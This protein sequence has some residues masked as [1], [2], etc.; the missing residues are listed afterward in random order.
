MLHLF[1]VQLS[2]QFESHAKLLITHA[3]YHHLEVIMTHKLAA[4][5]CHNGGVQEYLSEIMSARTDHGRTK[6]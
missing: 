4:Q 6:Y 2:L 3:D 5:L 1:G